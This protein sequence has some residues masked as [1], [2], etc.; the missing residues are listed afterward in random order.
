MSHLAAIFS[1][2]GLEPRAEELACFEHAKPAG[3][4]L[5]KRNIDNPTQLKTLTQSLKRSTGWDCPI[6]ID[7]E[8]GRVQRMGAPHWPP[9][10]AALAYE[11]NTQALKQAM[12]HMAEDLTAS[13]VTVNCAPTLDILTEATDNSIGD[14]AFGHD[15][16]TVTSCGR[17]VIDGFLSR[18]VTPVIKH[19]PGQG[20]AEVD[21]HISLP[22][23][24]T[25]HK[26][27]SLN[28]FL[29]FKTLAH[30]YGSRI[31]GMVAHIL[32]TDIDAELPSTLSPKIIKNIIR[33]EIGLSGFLLSDD[34]SMGAL[35]PYGDEIIRSIKTLEAG[36]DATLYCKGELEHMKALSDALP[37]LEGKALERFKATWSNS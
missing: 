33:D 13:G 1:L 6:L 5:F 29:P 7:Q 10:P 35:T 9:Y 11:G 14:R 32:Y 25:T 37:R 34:I 26:T 20:R 3:F 31:W 8:G 24:E 2:E 30:A 36:C 12:Q 28:D 23:V 27:L 15:V 18:G 21:S 22:V 17:A 19:M 16:E 4:I